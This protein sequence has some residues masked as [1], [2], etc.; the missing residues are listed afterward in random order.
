MVTAIWTILRFLHGSFED[1][2]LVPLGKDQ[3]Q[4]FPVEVAEQEE[5]QSD[6]NRDF[7]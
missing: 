7:E 2:D 6:H 1:D 4:H 5:V 3:D